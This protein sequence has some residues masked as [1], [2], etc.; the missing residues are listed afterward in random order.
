MESLVEGRPRLLARGDAPHHIDRLVGEARFM[1]EQ[2]PGGHQ[3][4]IEG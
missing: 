2:V 3:P 1:A 4:A